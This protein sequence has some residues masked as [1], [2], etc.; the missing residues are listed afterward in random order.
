MYGRELTFRIFDT[1]V[2]EGDNATEAYKPFPGRRVLT[3]QT[4]IVSFRE[5]RGLYPY[6]RWLIRAELVCPDGDICTE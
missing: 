1:L 6:E 5:E 2:I 3:L 4:S